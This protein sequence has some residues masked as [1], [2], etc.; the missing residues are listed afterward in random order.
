M[1]FIV[2]FPFLDGFNPY[3]IGLPILISIYIVYNRR[4]NRT[5]SILILLDYLFL[6][7]CNHFLLLI[8]M[9]FQSLFYWIT[10]SYIPSATQDEKSNPVSILILLDYLFLW[11]IFICRRWISMVSI[12]ILLDYLF[13]SLF[14]LS[15]LLIYLSFNPYFIGLPIL[16]HSS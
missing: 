5:V 16:I 14:Y 1:L 2:S 11:Y 12:L 10:Y 7:Y 6:F 9:A 15:L 8:L 3:F 13:L 4:W